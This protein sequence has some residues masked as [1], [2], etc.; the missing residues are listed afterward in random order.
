MKTF[1]FKGHT[2]ELKDNKSMYDIVVEN[3]YK[4]TRK[5]FVSQLFGLSTLKARIEEL[6]DKK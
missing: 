1:K 3:G 5:E 6:K 4:G 2:Y